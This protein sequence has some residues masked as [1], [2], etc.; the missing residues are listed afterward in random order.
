M[1]YQSTTHNSFLPPVTCLLLQRCCS[2][3]QSASA[4]AAPGAGSPPWTRCPKSRVFSFFIPSCGPAAPFIGMHFKEPTRDVVSVKTLGCFPSNKTLS[5]TRRVQSIMS[6][7]GQRTPRRESICHQKWKSQSRRTNMI[8]GL[9]FLNAVCSSF[10]CG[11]NY[12]LSTCRAPG[13]TPCGPRGG[14]YGTA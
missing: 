12:A 7:P 1:T 5:H 2:T 4:L 11:H 10:S 13:P 9:N 8:C 3:Q 6:T 14:T